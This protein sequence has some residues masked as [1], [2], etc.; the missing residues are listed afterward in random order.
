MFFLLSI[1][2]AGAYRTGVLLE[3]L[4]ALAS[5]ASSTF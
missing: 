5:T 2:V 4:L 1:D 3:L